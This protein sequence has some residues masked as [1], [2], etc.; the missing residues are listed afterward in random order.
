MR[1]GRQDHLVP[2]HGRQPVH[3]DLAGLAVDMLL[4]FQGQHLAPVGACLADGFFQAFVILL[5]QL[6]PGL[7][8]WH[9]DLQTDAADVA[10]AVGLAE[11]DGVAQALF[12]EQPKR[13]AQ[14]LDR[15]VFA[16]VHVNV[17]Q[18]PHGDRL[19]LALEPEVGKGQGLV[20]ELPVQSEGLGGLSLSGEELVQGNLK[21][22]PKPQG[23]DPHMGDQ[24][25]RAAAVEVL[26]E[27]LVGE[28][29]YAPIAEFLAEHDPPSLDARKPPGVRFVDRAGGRRAGHDR[30]HLLHR[31]QGLVGDGVGGQAADVG[32]GD[33]LGMA[34]ETG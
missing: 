2:G 6:E 27:E 4:A 14:T 29:F 5:G 21:I 7:A 16:D 31:L 19:M 15:P 9:G 3:Q 26:P 28:A 25:V 34:G 8:R 11:H 24:L 23:K 1:P 33:H 30:A 20:V 22:G 13:L 18:R 32:R 12:V 17:L 10:V